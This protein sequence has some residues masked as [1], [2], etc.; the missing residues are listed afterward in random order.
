VGGLQLITSRLSLLGEL[1]V[2][3]TSTDQHRCATECL[4]DGLAEIIFDIGPRLRVVNL[5][6]QL[7]H[8]PPW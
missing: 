7:P 8:L 4:A 3:G 5:D 2:G 1:Q 6:I